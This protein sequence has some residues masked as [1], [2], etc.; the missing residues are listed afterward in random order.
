MTENTYNRTG[1]I[2]LCDLAELIGT[3]KASVTRN[4]EELRE[5][6][7]KRLIETRTR[8]IQS[9]LT[10]TTEKHIS[11]CIASGIAEDRHQITLYCRENKWSGF[12]ESRDVILNTPIYLLSINHKELLVGKDDYIDSSKSIVQMIDDLIPEGFRLHYE[13]RG[14]SGYYTISIFNE[15]M[16]SKDSC[17][18]SVLS[19]Q[20]YDCYY[21]LWHPV[22]TTLC[23]PCICWYRW[24]V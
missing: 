22:L 5:K 10:C 21:C 16:I 2:Q 20:S 4:K 11:K 23:C 13:Y 12:D 24:D 15:S 9:I 14:S 6:E 19:C 18:F 17:F 8:F 3:E 7:E 1:K